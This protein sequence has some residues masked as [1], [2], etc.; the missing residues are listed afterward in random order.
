MRFA[1]DP[2]DTPVRVEYTWGMPDSTDDVWEVL[3]RAI[4]AQVHQ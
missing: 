1:T 3:D 4:D 2:L